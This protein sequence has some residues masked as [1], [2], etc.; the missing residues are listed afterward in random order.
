MEIHM[1]RRRSEH[2][3]YK[4][5]FTFLHWIQRSMNIRTTFICFPFHYFGII[6]WEITEKLIT[7]SNVSLSSHSG[8]TILAKV[9][10]HGA[11]NSQRHCC[12][13]SLPVKQLLSLLKK[14]TQ[15]KSPFIKKGDRDEYSI[16]VPSRINSRRTVNRTEIYCSL[17]YHKAFF[18]S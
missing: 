5:I 16:E 8:V 14:L 11:D 7:L 12:K 15:E 10:S 17:R 6:K 1:R 2:T 13:I 4:P 18:K 3:D 9:I